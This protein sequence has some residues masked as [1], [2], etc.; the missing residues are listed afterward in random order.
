MDNTDKL[1][2]IVDEAGYFT[3]STLYEAGT[4][5]LMAATTH[6]QVREAVCKAYKLGLEE[7]QSRLKLKHDTEVL[8]LKRDIKF[9]CTLYTGYIEKNAESTIDLMNRLVEAD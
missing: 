5:K 8:Q 2:Q 9:L 4:T 3:T 1:V 6:K 7:T